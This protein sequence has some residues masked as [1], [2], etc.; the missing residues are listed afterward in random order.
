[1]RVVGGVLSQRQ[2]GQLEAVG[3]LASEFDGLICHCAGVKHT[4]PPSELHLSRSPSS[5]ELSA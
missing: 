1:M 2:I 5:P 3:Y 4:L